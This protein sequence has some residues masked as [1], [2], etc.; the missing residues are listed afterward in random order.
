[1]ARP[2]GCSRAGMVVIAMAITAGI[3]SGQRP[4]G[5]DRPAGGLFAGGGGMAAAMSVRQMILNAYELQK[6]Q[7]AGGPQWLDEEVRIRLNLDGPPSPERIR[8]AIRR[9]L[10]DRFKLRMHSE[11]RDLEVYALV[12]VRADRQPGASLRM[13]SIE[14]CAKEAAT[15]PP[16]CGAIRLDEGELVGRAATM[17]QFVSMVNRISIMT[18]IDRLVIDRS[19]FTA[20]YT[21]ELLWLTAAGQPDRLA[22]RPALEREF[23]LR[24][25]PQRASVDVMVID[26]VE[27]P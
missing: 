21:F 20:A 8:Q 19:G 7:L 25:E 14:T 6:P 16:S 3:V 26:D 2:R 24:L 11:T 18:G 4:P 1:M 22:F 10:A 15:G 9:V 23:A 27:K 5:T 17:T 13:A 12:P